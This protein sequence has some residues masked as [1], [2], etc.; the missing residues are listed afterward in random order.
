MALQG[1]VL[2][3]TLGSKRTLKLVPALISGISLVQSWAL[4]RSNAHVAG[5]VWQFGLQA[6]ATYFVAQTNNMQRVA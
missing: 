2:Q 1:M 5:F 6:T 3:V 4:V